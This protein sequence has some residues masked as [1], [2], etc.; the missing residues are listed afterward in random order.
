MYSIDLDS[1]QR[2]RGK[3]LKALK[4][5]YGYN[6]VLNIATF[7]T[8]GSRSALLSAARGMGIDI[9]L[10]GYLTSLIP[11]ERGFTWSLSD[12]FFGNEKK[13]RK[14]VT[15]LLNAV[16]QYEGLKEN[17]LKIE[18][19]IKA[20]SV[21]ASGIYIFDED[22]TEMNAMMRAPSGQPTTQ[23][24]M[25]DSDAQGALKVDALTVQALDRVRFAMD[26]MI[27]HGFIDFDTDLRTTYNKHLHPDVLEYEDEKMW[28]RVGNNEIP[29][30]FQFDTSVGLQCAKKTQPRSIPE[31]SA[32]NSLMRLMAEDG[33]EQPMDKFVR[34]KNNINLW[35]EEMQQYELTEEE[36]AVLEKHLL[37]VY[38]VG[39]SQEVLME[40]SMDE[41]ISN[42]T[43]LEA[44]DL[45][46]VVGKKI[47]EDIPRIRALYFEKGKEVGNSHNILQYVWDTQILPQLGYSFSSLHST[48]Y[49]LIAL[50]EMNISTFFPDI[51]WA[52]ACLTVSANA[53][54]DEE[55]NEDEEDETKKKNK[56]TNYGKVA[57]SIGKMKSHGVTVA[58]PDVNKASF[59]F[60]P[61]LEENQI[62]YGLKGI[63]GIND[64]ISRII[65]ENR[66]YHS[67]DDFYNR[68][69][70][71]QTIGYDEDGGELTG[72]FL[73]RKHMLSL[74]KAGA[75]N[76]FDPPMEVMKQFVYKEI[77]KK[78][79]LN[80]QNIK[81]IIRLGLLNKPEYRKYL[82]AINLRGD[83]KK[84]KLTGDKLEQMIY[85]YD[86]PKKDNVY[87]ISDKLY[88][89][90]QL[91]FPENEGLVEWSSN[92]IFISDN[93]FDKEYKKFI[94][95][96]KEII[97]SP[98][99]VR[100][101]NIA[102]F[103]ELWF[104]IASGTVEKWEMES[105]SY[106]SSKHELDDVDR[107][108]YNISNFFEIDLQPEVIECYKYRGRDMQKFKIFT[109]IGTVLDKNKDKHT[110]TLLT[111]EG[112]VTCKT[113]AGAFAHYDKTI[114]RPLANGKKETVEKSWF[115]R[116]T[117]LM[118]KGF[119]RD[120]QFILRTNGQKGMEKE[121]TVNLILGVQDDG[122]LLLQD[123]RERV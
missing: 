3:I 103:Y 47:M 83:I 79:T 118:V 120:D 51:L 102:Q 64:E 89:K 41:K 96:L 1:E 121:H 56:A 4:K 87:I 40:L 8:E 31:L 76:K 33:K 42:F 52:T 95:P 98:E 65:I 77:D 112:V 6:R 90:Y 22:Y 116:G 73:Q 15:E 99:F 63:S 69:Y 86:L 32:A 105:V 107:D 100:E 88:S 9:D 60:T 16:E 24:D 45:R 61:D 123:E 59:G 122:S 57:S 48:G 43:M 85:D 49:S 17:A 29:D 92:G 11:N 34:F 68:L 36:V 20:R 46:K 27:E 97:A 44:N 81:S 113:Y 66:P 109:L 62:I 72:R 38:G 70:T 37:P 23:F 94:E 28:D 114:S 117:L 53:G 18:G 5:R 110:F 93:K 30:L 39:E 82:D 115:S 67:F 2:K 58:S 80:M 108:K 13:G 7:S 25:K 111:P 75:F 21:H 35:Y 10:I 50:Q 26:S 19:L 106:Y 74:I 119:R 84:K 91:L 14:P 104:N 101:F 12:C 78:E 54:E 55:F 71:E